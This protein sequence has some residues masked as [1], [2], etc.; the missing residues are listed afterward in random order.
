VRVIRAVSYNKSE[1]DRRRLVIDQDRKSGISGEY[2]DRVEYMLHRASKGH[3]M[4]W[5][6]VKG[7]PYLL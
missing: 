5:V 3:G 4:V 2:P 1:T 6:C 7:L